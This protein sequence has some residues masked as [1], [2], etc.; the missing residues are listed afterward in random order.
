MWWSCPFLPTPMSSLAWEE[1][2]SLSRS[3]HSL[4]FWLHFLTLIHMCLTPAILN[5][6][7]LLWAEL[8]PSKHSYGEALTPQSVGMWHVFRDRA[9][10]EVT[11]V[12]EVIWE[13]ANP[14]W[15]VA[16]KEKEIRIQRKDHVRTRWEGT[17]HTKERCLRRNQ[18]CRLLDLR[19][20]ELWA[21]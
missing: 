8:Y 19:P 20:P 3:G 13:G 9:L 10:K 7:L 15:L 6:W 14:T 4:T 18:T 12:N 16:L 2:L 1:D 5:R 21:Y 17:C 11:K